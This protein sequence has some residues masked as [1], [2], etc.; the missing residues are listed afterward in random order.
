MTLVRQV[1]AVVSKRRPVGQPLKCR[2]E[3]VEHA[4]RVPYRLL[5]LL[6][7]DV[8]EELFSR[9]IQTP[10]ASDVLRPRC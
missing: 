9:G 8:I 10:G 3:R 5:A 4:V 7:D 2:F 6:D 1:L